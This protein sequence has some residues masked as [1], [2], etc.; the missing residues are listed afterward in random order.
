MDQPVTLDTIYESIK[1]MNRKIDS[2]IPG[3]RF[4]TKKEIE[5]I[6]KKTWYYRAVKSGHLTPIKQGGRTAPAK[7][8]RKEYEN[9]IESLKS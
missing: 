7:I 8:E 1:L 2:L 5:A 3:N 4:I 6:H 9:Y